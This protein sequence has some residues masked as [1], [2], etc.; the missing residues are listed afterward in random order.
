M[1]S[2]QSNSGPVSMPCDRAV[3]SAVGSA[4]TGT[5]LTSRSSAS[6]KSTPPGRERSVEN[7]QSIGSHDTDTALRKPPRTSWKM[8]SANG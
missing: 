4:G 5:W 1:R 2:A 6:L 8:V 7:D 3:A